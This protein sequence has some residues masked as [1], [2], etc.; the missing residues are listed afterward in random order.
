MTY[1]FNGHGLLDHL[2]AIV[3]GLYD[4]L[5]T[6][7]RLSS[8]SL[9]DMYWSCIHDCFPP[10]T[11]RLVYDSLLC[12]NKKL[13]DMCLCTKQNALNRGMIY[14]LN[15]QVIHQTIVIIIIITPSAD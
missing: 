4:T 5:I 2:L 14:P 6:F 11:N 15:Q 9:T 1:T 8:C 13:A 10:I 3:V 12:V 7:A